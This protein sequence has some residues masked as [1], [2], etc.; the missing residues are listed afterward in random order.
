MT[1]LL[2]MVSD[3][4]CPWC[5]LG[6]RRVS[7]ALE[8]GGVDE[9]RVEL[10]FRPFELDPNVPAEGVDYKEYMSRRIGGPGINDAQKERFAAMRAALEA[11][12]EEEGLPFDFQN[13][14]HR[15]NSFDSHRLVRWAQGQGRGA[16]AKEALFHAYFAENR[17]V[18]DHA[19]LVDIAT[20]IGLD[21][22]VVSRLLSE[23][24]D[25]DAVRREAQFF[26]DLGVGGVP[27]L[28]A[29]RRIALQGAE[30][31]EKILKLI[32]AAEKSALEERPAG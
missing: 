32:E 28:I 24:A 29:D 20:Q 19:V 8:D 7:R 1:I 26:R 30:S 2:E 10:R 16:A 18:G 23:D 11:Y 31:T 27:T 22:D 3:V 17:N 15:P 5:W 9:D 21:S 25:K 14:K 6:L 4:V 13:M 12:G